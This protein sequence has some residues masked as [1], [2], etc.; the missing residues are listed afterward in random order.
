[1]KTVLCCPS[2]FL[3]EDLG[4]AASKLAAAMLRG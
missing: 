3:A 1:M 2:P 4:P